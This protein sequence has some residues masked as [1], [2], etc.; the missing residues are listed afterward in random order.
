MSELENALIIHVFGETDFASFTYPKSAFHG[1]S[2]ISGTPQAEI[3][4][5]TIG[6]LLG[7]DSWSTLREKRSP[8]GASYE[9]ALSESLKVLVDGSDDVDFALKNDYNIVMLGLFRGVDTQ[10]ETG[11]E[12]Q[13][14]A[15]HGLGVSR[16]SSVDEE[17]HA[18]LARDGIV[19]AAPLFRQ[20]IATGALSRSGI[21]AEILAD[22][23]APETAEDSEG[24]EPLPNMVAF[25]DTVTEK[26][27]ETVIL[28][29]CDAERAAAASDPDLPLV[30]GL[31]T[32]IVPTPFGPVGYW[33]W[34][35]APDQPHGFVQEQ[36]IDPTDLP[37]AGYDRLKA[38]DELRFL[39]VD[40]TTRL[41]VRSAQL[42]A[43]AL[44]LEAFETGAIAAARLSDE[45]DF[46]EACAWVMDNYDAV[47][48]L[49]HTG[50]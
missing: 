16:T 3:I 35:I 17:V 45:A 30:V 22:L 27:L 36:F 37:D 34:Q 50:R 41:S 1:E 29:A 14:F 32:A 28:C 24:E 39:L 9:E 13:V 47:D 38:S 48:F 23:D 49:D 40:R 12:E 10:S 5:K 18:G 4:T 44:G 31:V 7:H 6:A 26:G 2:Q 21:V 25:H 19:A 33:V 20:H 11:E 15:L 43:K 8:A 42:D 46:A